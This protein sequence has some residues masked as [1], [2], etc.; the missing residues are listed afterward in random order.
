MIDLRAKRDR[1]ISVSL[2][3]LT[4]L[5]FRGLDQ[6]NGAISAI[7]RPPEFRIAKI[8]DGIRSH[9][10]SLATSLES[11]APTPEELQGLVNGLT[12]S[13]RAFLEES[14]L[15]ELRAMLLRFHHR[16]MVAIE[17]LP[18]RDLAAKVEKALLQVAKAID[19]VDPDLIRKPIHEFFDK[20]DS[21]IKE[22][23][24]ADI[25]Q[26]INAVWQSVRDVFQQINTQLEDLKNTLTG[27]VG[28]VKDLMQQ[29]QPTLDSVSEGVNTIKTQL[30][31]FDLKEP[32]S[33]I[34]DDLHELRD[35]LAAVDFSKIPGPALSGLHVGAQL[36]RGLDVA[37]A[38]NPPLNDALAKV[39]PTPQLQ[40][41][42]ATLSSAT[43]NLRAIDPS[44]VVKQ[45]DKPVDELLK[46]L[47]EFG[48]EKLKGLLL[49]AIRPIEDAL[50]QLDFAHVLSPVT[51]LFA[52]LF[53]KVDAV[54]NPDVIFAPL[55]KLV[56]PVVDA[57]DA[58]KPTSLIALA[59]SHAGP[60]SEA[61]ASAAP[62][63]RRH[64]QRPRRAAVHPGSR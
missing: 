30:E 37:G 28:H 10:E 61:T 36:L 35:K 27:L 32:A 57:I 40:S 20:I 4:S 26:A 34:I 50:H 12:G 59:T 13:F 43:A 54:L 21:K 8:M 16:L 51:K 42:T 5:N 14:P 18:F 25:Q 44:N 60:I 46:V 2:S 56:Q 53:A 62:S 45:L 33:V 41:V 52:D 64:Q 9:I 48:P 55:D 22:I 11:W 63:S 38:V 17:S 19:I 7:A 15:G 3:N 6:L 49:E 24:L 39:D 47:N 1:L 29:I 23:P 31:S 58:V